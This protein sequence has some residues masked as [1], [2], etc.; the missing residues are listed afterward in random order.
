MGEV[1]K[2]GAAENGDFGE[3]LQRTMRSVKLRGEEG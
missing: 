3:G 1:E 2:G